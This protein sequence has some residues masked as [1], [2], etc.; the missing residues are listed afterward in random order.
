MAKPVCLTV[1]KNTRAKRM[2]RERGL[3][4][5]EGAKAAV[6]LDGGLSGFALFAWNAAGEP[7]TWWD[8]GELPA[9]SL[10][11]FARRALEN[12]QDFESE[13]AADG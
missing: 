8:C 13:Q 12:S 3:A 1:H 4:L 9:L 5:L 6:R 7:E 2:E 11:D 10:P